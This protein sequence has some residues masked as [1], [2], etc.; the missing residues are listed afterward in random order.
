MEKINPDTAAELQV[1]LDKIQG[2][3]TEYNYLG[4]E[5]IQIDK[6]QGFES[7]DYS[8]DKNAI[9]DRLSDGTY[10]PKYD[11]YRGATGNEERL[12]SQQGSFE[13]VING[14]TKNVIKVGAYA[15]DAIVGTAYGIYSGISHGSWDKV[16]NNDVSNSIDDF[17]KKLDNNLA[18][19]YSAEEKSMSVLRSMGTTNFWFNDV[20]G[21]F[22]FVAGA[23]LPELAIGAIT[24]GATAGVGL[25]RASLKR[26]GKEFAEQSIKAG[27]KEAAEQVGKKGLFSTVASKIPGYN[28]YKKGATALRSFE[29]NVLGKTAGDIFGTATFLARTSNFEAGMEARHNF[30]TSV[31]NFFT[32]FEDLNGRPPSSK[33]TRDFL[34]LAKSSANGVYAANLAILTVSNAVMFSN[35]FNIGVQTNK[36][37]KNSANHAIGL[38]TIAKKGGKR[39]MQVATKKQR[40]LGN[41]Y[42]ILSKPAVEG[43]YEEGFQ[44]VAGTTMQNYLQSKYN[45]KTEDTYDHWAALTD[46]FAHQY[47]SKEGWKEMAIGMIIGSMGGSIQGGPLMTGV[48]GK[49]SRKGRAA[50]I[51]KQVEVANKGVDTLVAKMNQS[52]SMNDLSSS[53]TEKES[54][55][56][57][58]F[59]ENSMLAQ[60]YIATQE[61]VKS[62][63]EILDDYDAIVDNMEVDNSDL[64]TSDMDSDMQLDNYKSSLK[65]E[66]RRNMESYNNAKKKVTDL[67]LEDGRRRGFVKDSKGNRVEI[68]KYLIRSMMLGE[69][70][71][72]GAKNTADIIGNL[73][74]LDGAFSVMEF[75]N[76]STNEQKVKIK[77]LRGK[78]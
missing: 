62:Q 44:G 8:I 67:G 47:S 39:A 38:G 61:A 5:P 36:A 48:M 58:T 18:N 37:L 24:G 69:N 75:F 56:E 6:E 60:E 3:G 49:T 54:N 15:T 27:T 33:D 7:V 64:S 46:A 22:A 10:T 20:A 68:E 25:A 45:P 13:K 42:F 41:A 17:N 53:I 51:E 73:V 65:G 72:H 74:G 34:E 77:E 50:T 76:N 4:V 32:D 11:N 55:Y 12:A 35:K 78:A 52:N 63:Q 29:T 1:I 23:L 43:L 57:S 16:W 21:G 66:F 31:E 71:L 40:V 59:V 19:Y 28:T 2:E 9:Y 70:A 30:H 26:G 14:L